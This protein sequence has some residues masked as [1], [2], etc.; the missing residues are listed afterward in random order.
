MKVAQNQNSLSIIA[1]IFKK[2]QND[3][4]VLSEKGIIEGVGH[5]FS[6]VLGKVYGL[7]L[8]FISSERPKFNSRD[9]IIRN[10]KS[11][12]YSTK[13][14]KEEIEVLKEK[15]KDGIICRKDEK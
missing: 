12:F 7:P 13:S 2:N 4:L 15:L 10:K 5:R 6:R 9:G 11:L 8:K 3:C 1:S 14:H